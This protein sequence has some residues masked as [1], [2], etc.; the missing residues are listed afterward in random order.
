MTAFGCALIALG[1]ALGALARYGLTVWVQQRLLPNS[2]F[3]WGT[4]I[5][6]VSGSFLLGLT[7]TL[8]GSRVLG[9]QWRPF[10][11]TGFLGAYTTFSTFEYETAQISSSWRAMANLV[12]SV[13][14]GYAAVLLGA[15]L[16]EI[17]EAGA[18]VTAR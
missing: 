12:G 18:K 8:V 5:I 10:F 14:V 9:P 2:T 4:F 11:A 3:P 6:N 15:R 7:V 17:V 1:G 13:A 16:A